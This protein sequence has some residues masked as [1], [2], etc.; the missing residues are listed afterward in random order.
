MSELALQ[1]IAEA[2]EQKSTR[3]NLGRCGLSSIPEELFDL[4]WLEDLTLADDWIE[5]KAEDKLWDLHIGK[6]VGS[7]NKI[8]TIPQQIK[9]LTQLR[10]LSLA[11]NE[12]QNIQALAELATL[13]TLDLCFND[14]IKDL[15]PLTQLQA[16]QTLQLRKN[17][18][19]DLRPLAKLRKLQI[20]EL[21][22]NQIKDLSPLAG[23][24]DLQGLFLSNN[25]ITNLQPLAELEQLQALYVA[26]NQI[27]D[28]KP[29]LKLIMTGLPL[30]L[31][32]AYKGSKIVVHDNPLPE[33][34]KALIKQGNPAVIDY[35]QAAKHEEHDSLWRRYWCKWFS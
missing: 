10:R 21:R 25:K 31:E 20:I 26:S 22:E 19:S 4:V 8:Q 11:G 35:Y 32:D 27:S 7:W 28:L 18:I 30:T 9:Q 12:I 13:Q 29:L 16:L 24:T 33:H 34:V 2:K 15:E 17:C 6:N 1:L 23:L 3:L 14:H 5:Y